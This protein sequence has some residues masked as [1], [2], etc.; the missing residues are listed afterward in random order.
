[1]H[2]CANDL[3]LGFAFC[4]EAI[5]KG[6]NLR[7]TANQVE[8]WEIPG[9]AEADFANFAQAGSALHGGAGLMFLPG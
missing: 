7:T 8:C 1:V 9:F 6:L 4:Q 5:A 2:D 3:H